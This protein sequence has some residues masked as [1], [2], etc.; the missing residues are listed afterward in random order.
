MTRAAAWVRSLMEAG[1]KAGPLKALQGHMWAR[2]YASGELRG[3]VYVRAPAI[4]SARM[5]PPQ[6]THACPVPRL[7][8][9][10]MLLDA[11]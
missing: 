2:G 7:V 4:C 5:A 11:V 8:C 6:S 1:S 10:E 9:V 3:D